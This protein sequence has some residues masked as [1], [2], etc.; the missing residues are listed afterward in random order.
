MSLG[1]F[2]STYVN[3]GV[4]TDL[5]FGGGGGAEVDIRVTSDRIFRGS[6]EFWNL[7]PWKHNLQAIWATPVLIFWGGSSAPPP[8]I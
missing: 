6:G 1:E 2:E 5:K 4:G 7:E 8:P 3:R